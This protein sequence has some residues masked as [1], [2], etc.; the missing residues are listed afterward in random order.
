M[1]KTRSKSIGR[2]NRKVC[3]DADSGSDTHQAAEDCPE[4]K[5]RERRREQPASRTL[6]RSQDGSQGS[7]WTLRRTRAKPVPPEVNARCVPARSSWGNASKGAFHDEGQARQCTCAEGQRTGRSIDRS[8]PCHVSTRVRNRSGACR[9]EC[10][11]KTDS[12]KLTANDE[13]FALAA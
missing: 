10:A 13:R 5:F 7:F 4:R 6:R 3:S 12:N 8:E 11:R 9:A 2:R 1:A